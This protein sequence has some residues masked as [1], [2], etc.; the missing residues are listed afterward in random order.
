MKVNDQIESGLISNQKGFV[1]KRIT[2]DSEDAHVILLVSGIICGILVLI[3]V[4]LLYNNILSSPSTDGIT[5]CKVKIG[6]FEQRGYYT[7]QQQYVTAL[8]YC[9]IK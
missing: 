4:M 3:S 8:S 1:E 9:N 5:K 7:T 6:S 2:Y